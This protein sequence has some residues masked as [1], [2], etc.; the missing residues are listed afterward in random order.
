MRTH[1]SRCLS[2]EISSGDSTLSFTTDASFHAGF[3]VRFYSTVT[4]V[5]VA[6][7]TVTEVVVY[8]RNQA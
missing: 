6:G 7:S 4:C 1:N 5:G 3:G 2:V 8:N